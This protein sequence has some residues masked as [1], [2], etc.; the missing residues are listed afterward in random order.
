MATVAALTVWCG[1]VLAGEIGWWAAGAI[2]P[3]L[4]MRRI[5]IVWLIAAA[6]IAG[7]ASSVRQ[8][9]THRAELPVGRVTLA[10][11]LVDDPRP[12]MNGW[13]APF[14]PAHLWDGSDWSS[15]S[16]P[17]LAV[18]FDTPALLQAGDRIRVEGT[19]RSW[20][21][22]IRSDPVAGVVRVEESAQLASAD[23]PLFRAGNAARKRVRRVLAGRG[24]PA[25]LVS[26][27]LIGDVEQ[28]PPRDQENL[29]RAG[30][31]HF[32]AVSGSNVALFLGVWF[33]AVGPLGWTPLRR[34]TLGVAGLLLFVVV[35]RWEPSVVRASVMA[36]LVLTGRVVGIPL[37]PWAALGWAVAASLLVAPQLAGQVGFQLSVAA[38]AG[39]LAG[40]RIAARRTA[41]RVGQALG[42]T[43][44]AQAAVAPLLL[45]HF[46]SVPLLAPVTNLLAAPFVTAATGLGGL[47]VAT[48][49][50]FVVQM[51]LWPANVVLGIARTVSG[52]PQMGAAGVAA[53]GA[54]ALVWTHVRGLR[55]LVALAVALLLVGVLLPPPPV[56]VPTIVFLDVGQGDAVL[57]LTPDGTT[58]LVDGGPE[59]NRLQDAL[60]R[61][62]VRRFDMVV[63]TH[64]DLD[65]IG[66]LEA[67]IETYQV[68]S[69]WHP[70][71]RAGSDRYE[72]LL[73][74]ARRNGVEL[75]TPQP[76]W[77]ARF[78]TV[79][80]DVL[81]PAR[82]YADINDESI[83]L[84]IA[85]PSKSVLLTGDIGATAQQELGPVPVDV[86]K[87]PHHGAATTNLEWLRATAA[88]VAVISVGAN[89]FGHPAEEVLAVLDASGSEV[90]R[91]D[92]EGDIAVPLGP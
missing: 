79:T 25:A 64:G 61:W 38:T 18:D 65:H 28:L 77:T 76:G 9:D 49:T 39:V 17:R 45:W 82:R 12:G 13:R 78:G 48:G 8:A 35:T 42:V 87:V 88:P 31:S 40:G 70:G 55:P 33:I 69:L 11:R 7:T 41:N 51:A 66:G 24:P 54:A 85:T 36:G 75:S 16:G 62:G 71:H 92:E 83:V 3:L 59:A 19:L 67:I 53:V 90:R 72:S 46:G 80:V 27:F 29:R 6:V 20:S 74:S 2:V 32:V 84:R 91:T 47:G 21:G 5:W 57:V 68:G 73:V 10:G 14:D 26:G 86:L 52:W 1:V 50:S 34:A 44:G 43:M 60:E 56:T 89:D 81:G 58:V 23:D 15:W 22:W 30:L 4:R 63:A 37:T